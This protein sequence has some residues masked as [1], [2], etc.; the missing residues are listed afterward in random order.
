VIYYSKPGKYGLPG[1]YGENVT[2][3]DNS[4]KIKMKKNADESTTIGIINKKSNPDLFGI[5]YVK[6]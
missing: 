6:F 5:F 4:K 1:K 3:S 2:A